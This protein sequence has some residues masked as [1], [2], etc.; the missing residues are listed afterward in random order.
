MC[1]ADLRV[2]PEDDT[3][4]AEG[5][6]LLVATDETAAIA[7]SEIEP[8]S[9]PEQETIPEPEVYVGIS[10]ELDLNII[11]VEDLVALAEDTIWNTAKP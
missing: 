1:F 6:T 7:E 3:F 4:V 10:H 9:E 11:S 8:V 5:D 2:E